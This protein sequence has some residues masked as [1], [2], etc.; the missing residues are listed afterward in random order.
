MGCIN[1][2]LTPLPPSTLTVAVQPGSEVAVAAKPTSKAAVQAQPTSKAS[3]AAMEHAT[4]A[5]APQKQAV[6]TIGEICVISDGELD[7][8]AVTAGALRTQNG[9]FLLLRPQTT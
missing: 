4:V 7:A 9:G 2:T 3:V 1:L 5:A 6:L 8:L